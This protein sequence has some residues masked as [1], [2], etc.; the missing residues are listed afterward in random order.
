MHTLKEVFPTEQKPCHKCK[1]T[2]Y[3][4]FAE[5]ATIYMASG[6][7]FTGITR[8]GSFPECTKC[9][10]CVDFINWEEK[11]KS[12][13]RNGKETGI[14]AERMACAELCDSLGFK[15]CAEAIRN[16]PLL[17]ETLEPRD[18]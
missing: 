6:L 1:G 4:G 2:F 12:S 18:V 8:D 5:S 11:I 15:E 7:G 16:R 10:Y 3:V 9:L 14:L 13:H 17:Q